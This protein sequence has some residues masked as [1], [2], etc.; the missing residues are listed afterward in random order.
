M[1]TE[2]TRTAQEQIRDAA[3]KPSA[4]PRASS[5]AKPQLSPAGAPALRPQLETADWAPA[6]AAT[7]GVPASAAHASARPDV[8]SAAN[9]APATAAKPA[10]TTSPAAPQ[11]PAAKLPVPSSPLPGTQPK[12]QPAA[13]AAKV[14]A[15]PGSPGAASPPAQ[16]GAKGATPA[17]AKPAVAKPATAGSAAA[18]PPVH[19]AKPPASI[20]A[21]GKAA[22]SAAAAAKAPAK[23]RSAVAAIMDRGVHQLGIDREA[24][25]VRTH[26]TAAASKLQAFQKTAA[27]QLVSGIRGLGAA[28]ET[29]PG[30]P[31]PATATTKAPPPAAPS[32]AKKQKVAAAPDDVGVSA[33]RAVTA[34][35]K[36]PAVLPGAV[37][38]APPGAKS[39]V[40]VSAGKAAGVVGSTAAAKGSAVG[41]AAAKKP[42]AGDKKKPHV[43]EKVDAAETMHMVVTTLA[44]GFQGLFK[45]AISIKPVALL[46]AVF[47]ALSAALAAVAALCRSGVS[48]VATADMITVLAS[49]QREAGAEVAAAVGVL[50]AL[51]HDAVEA[52][53]GFDGEAAVSA[54]RGYASES[55]AS[56]AEFG[57]QARVA[58]SAAAADAGAVA[59]SLLQKAQAVD[60][61]GRLQHAA[62]PRLAAA[63]AVATDAAVR[64]TAAADGL[65]TRTAAMDVT[66]QAQRLREA[67]TRPDG[68][69]ADGAAAALSAARDAGDALVQR[70]ANFNVSGEA[71]HLWESPSAAELRDGG[72]AAAV[73]LRDAAQG[74]ARALADVDVAEQARRARGAAKPAL[75]G[76]LSAAEAAVAQLQTAAADLTAHLQQVDTAAGIEKVR[77]GLTA[78][79]K[80]A[81]GGADALTA[82]LQTSAST[83]M[84]R[85]GDAASSLDLAGIQQRLQAAATALS[86]RLDAARGQA[87]EGAVPSTS[88]LQASA[89]EAAT[90]L[91][92][93]LRRAAEALGKGVGIS[94][95]ERVLDV[96][97]LAE[98]SAEEAVRFASRLVG[99]V[100]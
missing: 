36:A 27:E 88:A 3:A 9:A 5:A 43:A 12:L 48:F 67:L 94:G 15:V 39:A 86:A 93:A 17:V 35:K 64:A 91:E 97:G 11:R 30:V 63:S 72:A 92:D 99:R 79:G 53:R 87:F 16:S 25:D 68:A 14:S 71:W 10:A 95:G 37:A 21:G 56:A 58:I 69:A 23:P 22:V 57:G 1:F 61:P 84:G 75:D 26:A 76:A 42:G 100:W 18:K 89:A 85:A 33:V 73:S 51:P 29:A 90:Q 6:L 49:A 40:T 32:S 66:L 65:L 44:V 24:R 52:V 74:F 50:Q 7:A 19:T 47:L 98:R 13:A 28:L 34:A 41:N 46:R 78:L 81:A 38:A 60:L 62:A 55:L 82:D 31:H 2:A 70:L 77:S 59:A 8:F 4:V 96:P 20:P 83:A 45:T 80:T 54:A